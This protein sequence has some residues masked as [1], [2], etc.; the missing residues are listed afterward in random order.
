MN[1]KYTFLHTFGVL[2]FNM[3]LSG[4]GLK[5]NIPAADQLPAPR[6]WDILRY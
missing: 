2:L 4:K 3:P 6:S 1:K 5:V